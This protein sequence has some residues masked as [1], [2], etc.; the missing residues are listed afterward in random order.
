MNKLISTNINFEVSKYWISQSK[1]F[2]HRKNMKKINFLSKNWINFIKI[3]RYELTKQ[4]Y[5]K[6]NKTIQMEK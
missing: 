5:N 4:T 1:L 6:S 3:S 2:S